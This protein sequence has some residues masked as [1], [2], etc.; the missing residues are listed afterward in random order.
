M[1]IMVTGMMMPASDA[2]LR[3]ASRTHT[4]YANVIARANVNGKVS[5]RELHSPFNCFEKKRKKSTKAY[6]LKG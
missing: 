5:P 3:F 1:T 6:E 4:C 2:K